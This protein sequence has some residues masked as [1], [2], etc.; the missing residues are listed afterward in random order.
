M[1][2][3]DK[4]KKIVLTGHFDRPSNRQLGQEL[5]HWLS[6]RSTVVAHN[7]ND[8][9]NLANLPA[10]EYIVVV[11]GDGTILATARAIQERPIPIIG[12]N[13]GKLGYLAEF[14]FAQF[15]EHFDRL[16]NDP[17]LITRRIMLACR[18]TGP[19]RPEDYNT[20]AVNEV[21]IVG[22]PPFRMVEIS[23]SIADEHLALCV[24]DGLII[25]TPTGSTA[26]NLSAGGPILMSTLPVAV[27]TPLAAHSLSFR[28][29]V[30]DLAKPIIL[31]CR[32]RHSLNVNNNVSARTH[33]AMAV[34]GQD[35]IQLTSKDEI[36]ISLASPSFLL[37]RNPLQGQWR[38]LNAKLN[39]G[40]MPNYNNRGPT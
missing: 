4:Q 15:T 18:V 11:G 25:A 36:T 7:L 8:H 14:S 34:D 9:L 31:H 17:D 16:V 6:G 2:K 12:I 38:L 3:Q 27:I 19:D 13:I 24:G 21:A 39:W 32:P 29:V 22:E 37:V 28:P 1:G 23:I 30:V 26:Y 40:A 33:A 35:L 5:L 10:A 20:T